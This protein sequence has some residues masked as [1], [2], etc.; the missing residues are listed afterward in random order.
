M[1][2]MHNVSIHAVSFSSKQILVVA[3]KK[4]L[5]IPEEA[6]TKVLVRKDDVWGEGRYWQEECHVTKNSIR[7]KTANLNF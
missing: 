6:R 5:E 3:M 4:K 2:A 1:L 7:H